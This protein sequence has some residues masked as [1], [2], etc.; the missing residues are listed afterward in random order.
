LRRGRP[1]PGAPRQRQADTLQGRPRVVR[2]PSVDGDERRESFAEDLA[3][4]GLDRALKASRLDPHSDGSITP[5]EVRDR[6]RIVR[7]HRPG[8]LL[9]QRAGGRG[10]DRRDREDDVALA[11]L[12]VVEAQ[13]FKVG[14][15]AGR[16]DAHR[17]LRGETIAPQVRRI[18][19]VY[20]CARP[21]KCVPEPFD[22]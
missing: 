18:F 6:P 1:G 10:A 13:P 20:P 15:E 4:T 11:D 3:R 19:M 12:D 9:A 16:I 7:M 14:Q 22:N 17:R 21:I 8:A 5:W 2:P